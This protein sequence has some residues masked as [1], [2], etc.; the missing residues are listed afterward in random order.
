MPQARRAVRFKYRVRTP[1]ARYPAKLFRWVRSGLKVE[2]SP[3]INTTTA[4]RPRTACSARA[5]RRPC[6]VNMRLAGRFIRRDTI[7]DAVETFELVEA[8]PDDKYLPSYLVLGRT[9]G[10]RAG[11]LPDGSRRG[12]RGHALPQRRS[13]PQAP[14]EAPRRARSPA[15]GSSP[16]T[17]TWATGRPSASCACGTT[18]ASRSCTSGPVPAT[19]LIT[20]R[21]AAGG[22]PLV[23]TSVP[24]RC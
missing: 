20:C 9:G 16:T 5:D 21:P 8:Y 6:H 7:L 14:P 24:G 3:V 1:L 17:S 15:A 18:V 4:R 11:S 2:S 23:V 12:H 13:Q 10:R 19:P 22:E